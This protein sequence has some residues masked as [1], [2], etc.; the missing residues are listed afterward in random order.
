MAAL[1]E[2]VPGLLSDSASEEGSQSSYRDAHDIPNIA[3]DR[4]PDLI[5]E[6]SGE[7]AAW[8]NTACRCRCN[9]AVACPIAYAPSV[10]L[11][12]PPLTDQFTCFFWVQRRTA[13]LNC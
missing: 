6:S 13:C 5:S 9:L 2:E 3:A 8:P 7:G 12:L 11:L 4:P 10:I 1:R